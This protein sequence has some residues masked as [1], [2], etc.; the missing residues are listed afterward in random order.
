MTRRGLLCKVRV[1]PYG[2]GLV[3]P[4]ERTQPGPK[5]DR[6]DLGLQG[7]EDLPGLGGEVAAV[8]GTAFTLICG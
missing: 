6:L 1:T 5:Q 2:P 8:R 7:P 3:R 4:H